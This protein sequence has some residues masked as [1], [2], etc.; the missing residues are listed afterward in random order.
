MS[1]LTSEVHLSSFEEPYRNGKNH[2][3]DEIKF[4]RENEIPS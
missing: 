3:R 4:D 2:H 1:H